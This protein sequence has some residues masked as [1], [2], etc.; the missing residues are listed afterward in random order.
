MAAE[1]KEPS[2]SIPTGERPGPVGGK[3]DVNRKA[4]TQSLLDA[5]RALS[6]THGVENVSIDDITREAGVAKGSFYRYF[7]DKEALIRAVLAPIR[8][9]VLNAFARAERKLAQAHTAEQ[10]RAAYLRLGR[11]LA[12]VI[13]G[14]PQTSLL[15]LQET[16]A[17][18]GTGRLPIREL[19]REIAGAGRSL[20]EV[21][22]KHGLLRSID[23][24]VTSLTV[25]GAVERLLHAYFR[26]DLEVAPVSAMQNL[27]TIIF[28]GIR[29]T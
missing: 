1:T 6:L 17:P 19:E 4:K 8:E 12:V 15:Y 9:R 16:R 7:T 20:T 26:G 25:I 3:R 2:P 27:V 24:Q 13:I 11:D 23:A 14:E 18:G 29:E 28:E 5:G 10:A 21:A 22:L